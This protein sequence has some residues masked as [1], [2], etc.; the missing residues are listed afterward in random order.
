MSQRSPTT[1]S[2]SSSERPATSPS[3]SCFPG[4]Y[5]LASAGLLPKRY[6]IIGTSPAS[7]AISPRAV[8]EARQGLDPRVRHREA[9][10]RHVEDV[11]SRA[12]LRRRRSRQPAAARRGGREGREGDRRAR[13]GSCTTSRSRPSRSARW[14]SMLGATGLNKDAHVIIEK[15]FGYRPRE[16]SRPERDRA[17]RVRRVVHLPHRPL[18]REG[19]DRQHPGVPLRERAVRADLEPQPRELRADR[20]AR[21]A[22]HR[23]TRRVLRQDRRVPRHDRDPPV[24]GA[25][26]RRDGAAVVTHRQGAARREG[27]GLRIDASDRREPSRAGAVQGLPRRARCVE[28][29]PDR[30]VHRR[31]GRRRQLALAGR[32]V[33]PPHGQEPRPE[34][35]GHHDRVPRPGAQDVPGERR[36]DPRRVV[37]TSS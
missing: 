10:G 6:R 26:L 21:D 34:P 15:P 32:A 9:V 14:S 28:A 33:L 23:G 17:R 29:L 36:R 13:R 11:R 1:T 25:R 20:R 30:D 22:V 16:R 7:F 35:P 8:P 27:E 2:S 4:L 31:E 19:G 12:R 18:P 37:A 5:H 24:A 3:A